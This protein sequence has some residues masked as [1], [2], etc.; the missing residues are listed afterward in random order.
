M[1]GEILMEYGR[2]FSQRADSPLSHTSERPKAERHA[3][4]AKS[5]AIGAVELMRGTKEKK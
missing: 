2:Y 4:A 5:E 3:R 1:W